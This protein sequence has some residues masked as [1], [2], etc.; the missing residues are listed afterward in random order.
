MKIRTLLISAILAL[1]GSPAFSQTPTE[2]D[3]VDL[4]GDARIAACSKIIS[5]DPRAAWAYINRGTSWQNKGDHDRAISDYNKAIELDPK[6][7]NTYYNRGLSLEVKNKLH[8]ALSDFLRFSELA[9]NDPDGPKKVAQ[10]REKLKSAS[11]SV[12]S[13]SQPPPAVQTIPTAS[14]TS[15]KRVALLIGNTRYQNAAR[16]DNPKNDVELISGSFKKAGFST[17]LVKQD[18]G[19]NDFNA[20]LQ[21]FA[22]IADTADVAVIYYAG[23]AIEFGGVNYLIPVDAKLK[24]DRD[25]SLQTVEA[26]KLITAMSGSKKLKM[27]ILDACRDNPF[28]TQMART[29][30]SRSM[31]RG[32]ARMEADKGEMIVYSARAGELADDGQGKNSPFAEAFAKR[33]QND[34]PLELRWFFDHVRDDVLDS[35]K[36]KQQPFTYHSLPSRESF[37]FTK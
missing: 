18:L 7:A 27:L 30:A 32:L 31:G 16:L 2:K 29:M 12:A 25:I 26:P 10:I 3:C 23:H 13:A 36:G 17:V 37:F 4:S 20:A 14:A 9:P 33:L 21:E 1:M 8:D 28:A 5:L 11:P 19:V 6:Y 22:P 24:S 15:T 34:P 35:T